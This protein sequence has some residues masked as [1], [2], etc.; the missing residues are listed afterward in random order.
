M[1]KYEVTY[2]EMREVLQWG[3]N[4]NRI[5]ISLSTTPESGSITPAAPG[6]GQLLSFGVHQGM[7]SD[8]RYSAGTF[9]VVAGRE[10]FPCN[11]VTWLGA[12]VYCNMRS[13]KE[14]LQ[15]CYNFGDW[16]NDHITMDMTKNGY[17]LP[18][19]AEWEKAARGGLVG[20]HFPWD[21]NHGGFAEHINGSKANY[22]NSGDPYSNLATPVGYYNGLQ[23][24]AGVDMA[25]GYGLYDMAGNVQEWCWDPYENTWYTNANAVAS[26]TTGPV[27]KK[28]SGNRVIRGGYYSV[29]SFFLRCSERYGTSG[30]DISRGFRCVR[31]P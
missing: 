11:Y 26:D 29:W 3:Y 30:I 2:A 21:S 7:S 27:P 20:H 8:L 9:S 1:A 4:N 13:E 16:S 22:N 10:N 31:R 15:P 24:P 23:T 18:T 25:N 17:R 12:A 6:V 14:G 5:V 19:E 28:T